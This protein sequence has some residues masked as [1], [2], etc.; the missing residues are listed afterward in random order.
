MMSPKDKGQTSG[1][2]NTRCW[3]YKDAS[4]YEE[5][6]LRAPGQFFFMKILYSKHLPG[7]Q[8]LVE[9]TVSLNIKMKCSH[10]S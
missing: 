4:L 10:N 1:M 9:V 7:L 6:A 2:I 3:S 5:Q 8:L